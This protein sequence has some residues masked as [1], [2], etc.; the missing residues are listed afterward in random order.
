VPDA[1]EP[2]PRRSVRRP[3]ICE[4]CGCESDDWAS[5]WEGD[6]AIA[7]D[8]SESIVFFCPECVDDLGQ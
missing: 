6:L 5:G 4:E 7:D 3:L 8:G 2:T 1:A